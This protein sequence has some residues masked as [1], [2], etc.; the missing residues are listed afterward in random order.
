[1]TMPAF[2]AEASL[3]ATSE[4]YRFAGRSSAGRLGSVVAQQPGGRQSWG[5][6]G[7]SVKACVVPQ[8]LRVPPEWQ[9]ILD[10]PRCPLGCVETANPLR[11]CYCGP[12]VTLDV[13]Q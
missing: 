1:M 9:L 3:Y 12:V 6:A 2:T 4:R 11:P 5:P 8:Q 10:S 13:S 7:A